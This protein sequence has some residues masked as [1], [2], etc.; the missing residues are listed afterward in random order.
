MN[1]AQK[2]LG[3]AATLLSSGLVL[4]ASPDYPNLE[5]VIIVYKTHFDIGYS[6]M[7]RDVVHKYRTE[8]LDHTLANIEANEANPKEHQFTWTVPGWP[9]KQI[10]WQGQQPERR[11]LI[12]QAFR[13]GNLVVHAL[14]FTSHTEM[15]ELEPYVRGMGFSSNLSRKYGLELPRD[16]KMTDVPSHVWSLPTILK[17][18]GVEFF[19]LGCNSSNK[20]PLTPPLF[21]WEGPDG[22]RVMTMFSQGYGTTPLPPKGW[23][24]KAWVYI[25]QTGDNIGAPSIGTVRSNLDFYKKT[26]PG[27]KV[28]IGRL[29]DFADTIKKSGAELPVVRLDMPDS[30]I[31]GPMGSPDAVAQS[32]RTMLDTGTGETMQTQELLWG[33]CVPDETATYRK[34]YELDLLFGEHTWGMASQHYRTPLYGAAWDQALAEGLPDYLKTMEK[35]W[36]EHSQYIKTAAD[37]LV[38][39]IANQIAALAD[40]V[41]QSGPRFVV[42]NP[43][44]WKRSGLVTLDIYNWPHP[45]AVKPSDS[46][47][48]IPVWFEGNAEVGEHRGFVTFD[49]RDIPPMG[50]RTFTMV[51]G[52]K[53][54]QQPLVIDEKT[55]TI[56]SPYFK[57]RLNAQKGC[58][59]SL[60]D[61]RTQR[62]WIDQSAPHQF[63]Q[64]L[65]ERFGKQDVMRFLNAYLYPQHLGF[66]GP[67]T[68]R[69]SVPNDSVYQS[70]TV[71]N[72]HISFHKTAQTV[73]AVMTGTLAKPGKPQQIAM[74]L[75]LYADHPYADWKVDITKSPDSWPE[76]GWICFP[77]KLDHPTYHLGRLGCVTE[78]GKG[79]ADNSNFRMLWL[80]TG[81]AVHNDKGGMGLCPLDSPLI[82][83]GEPGCYRFDQRYSPQKPYVYINLYNNAWATNFREWWGGRLCSTVRLW[84]FDRYDNNSSL[85][86]PALEARIPLLAG[87][88]AAKPG[89]LPVSQSGIELSRTGI[90]ITTFGKNPDGNGLLLRLWEQSGQSGP[91]EIKFPATWNIRSLQPVDLRGRA[92]GDPILVKDHKASIKINGFS[93]AS[94]LIVKQ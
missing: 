42:Y 83:L 59:E 78:F 73:S 9:M 16:A 88:S 85:T 80:N 74:T 62:E 58:I 70:A 63:G 87:R 65:Y 94:F 31:H 10:L 79:M 49:A 71:S 26:L 53:P 48:L 41:N 33:I 32:R 57:V 76:A 67:V 92:S 34:A 20:M 23:P 37:L 81:T 1:H 90:Q 69:M 2:T 4:A 30:W 61:K 13:N 29:S 82:S 60:V 51:T 18:A 91:C 19:H 86:K 89:K 28:K 64:Y 44:P 45:T 72:T 84:T 8:M 50:Y 56:E 43:L 35:S 15:N 75:T 54:P 39:P 68:G 7:A 3:I 46:D 11:Q 14:P 24:Y 17:H 27:V 66:I 93:P 25:N 47:E 36:D 12:E 77:L 5:E 52:P 21:W 40:S 22:S 38:L 6:A 55:Q